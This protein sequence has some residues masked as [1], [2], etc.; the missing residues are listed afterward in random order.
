MGRLWGS[1]LI[2]TGAVLWYYGGNVGSTGTVN[3]GIGAMV[4]GLVL[5]ALPQRGHLDR[6]AFEI[7]CAGF[8]ELIENAVRDARLKGPPV[9]IPPYENLPHG[10]IFLPESENA[11][12][13]LG[14]VSEGTVFITGGKDES[15]ILLTPPPGS[16]IIGYTI[17]NVGELRETGVGYASSAVSS[18]LSA[19]GLGSAEAFEE[20][21][22]IELFVKPACRKSLFDPAVAAMLLGIAMGKNELLKVASIENVREYIKLTLEPIGGVEKWL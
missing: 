8:P 18:V 12:V 7:S 1:V 13:S 20:G 9:V 5:A 22:R 15:G 19:L 11:I 21:E 6:E 14:R 3:L 4:L 10:G 2:I 16:E 17:E